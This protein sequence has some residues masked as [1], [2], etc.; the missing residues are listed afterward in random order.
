[1]IVTVPATSA[2]M[3]PGF[4]SLGVAV[5]LYNTIEIVPARF[6]SISVK[7]EGAHFLKSRG[8][9]IFLKLF[10]ETY[11]KLGGP[12]QEFR[13]SFNN[14]IPLSRGLGSSS[15]VIVSAL[16]AAYA[17][18]EVQIS[19]RD[20][21]NKALKYEAHPDNI[22]PAVHGGF[23][24]AA[25]ERGKVYNL[26]YKMPKDLKAVVV[27]P[28]KPMS[29]KSS[30][31]VLPKKVGMHDLVFNLSRSSLL[32]A[33][34][35]TGRYELLR[36][37]SKDRLHQFARMQNLPI[38]FDVQKTALRSGAL[39]STLSGSGSTFFNL[40]HESDAAEIAA[41]L[42]KRFDAFRVMTLDFDNHGVVIR[43]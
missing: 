22:T 1:M 19:K 32:T 20:L 15:A 21:L 8:G 18:A 29:T 30:R 16:A 23:N 24:A 7:G 43:K 12:Q 4:D 14:D 38:L 9:N 25:V 26:T 2:N 28:D 34:L 13:F 37:A 40:V 33:A 39:M 27:I 31:T 10:T 3:G 36:V 11:K 5:S 41:T 42:E 6:T 17:V 35:I